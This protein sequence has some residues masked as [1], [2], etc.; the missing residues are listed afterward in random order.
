[1]ENFQINLQRLT[2]VKKNK[3]TTV[4][5]FTMYVLHRFINNVTLMSNQEMKDYICLTVLGR[6][7]FFA[8]SLLSPPISG[9][10]VRLLGQI[11]AGGNSPDD[12]VP[13]LG[14]RLRTADWALDL[15]PVVAEIIKKGK[16]SFLFGKI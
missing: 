13:R 9:V 12:G 3:I 5:L 6:N 14:G 7:I 8:G 4:S 16:C 15:L 1:M 2:R 10:S 11:M